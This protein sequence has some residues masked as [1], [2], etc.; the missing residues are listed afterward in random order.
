ML[1]P[2]RRPSPG[3]QAEHSRL[4]DSRTSSSPHVSRGFHCDAQDSAQA[5]DPTSIR[6]TQGAP[7]PPRFMFGLEAPEGVWLVQE[8]RSTG[9]GVNRPGT[10]L[11]AI[12]HQLCALGASVSPPTPGMVLMAA[13]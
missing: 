5:L 4:A 12:Y 2:A 13:S 6:P 11:T 10:D 1:C 7:H 8:V 9:S 3:W